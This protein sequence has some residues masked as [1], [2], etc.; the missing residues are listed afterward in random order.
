MR[1]VECVYHIATKAP[2]N[3]PSAPAQSGYLKDIRRYHSPKDLTGR[4]LI[5]K[6]FAA[7]ENS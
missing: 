6:Y 7:F 5:G 2:L 3:L 1:Q 4:Q